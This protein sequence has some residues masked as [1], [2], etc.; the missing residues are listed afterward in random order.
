MFLKD[1]GAPGGRCG[2]LPV[3]LSFSIVMLLPTPTL[4][5]LAALVLVAIA[6][7]ARGQSERV[8]GP[9]Q[10]PQDPAAAAKAADEA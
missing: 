1:D 3:R 6:S 9:D 2:C 10:Q 4:V 7:I 8:L 5:P